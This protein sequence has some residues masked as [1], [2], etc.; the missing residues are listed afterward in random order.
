MTRRSYAN[1]RCIYCTLEKIW[2][3]FNREHV[4]HQ[5]MGK[6][7]DALVLRCVCKPC[8]QHFG[9]T[10]D[11]V[12]GRQSPESFVRVWKGLTT[13]EKHRQHSGSTFIRVEVRNPEL[14]HIQMRAVSTADGFGGEPLKQ[15][16]FSRGEHRKSFLVSEIP[17]A[18]EIANHGFP[19]DQTT[20]I[21]LMGEGPE[22]IVA[23]MV[24]RGYQ[25]ALGEKLPMP[26]QTFRGELVLTVTH[27]HLRA[28]AKIA[29][30]Y[31][32]SELGA[33]TALL[34]QFDRIRR[35]I[36]DD[37]VTDAGLVRALPTSSLTPTSR[38]EQR[39]VHWIALVQSGASLVARV[40]LFSQI[41]YEVLLTEQP[42]EGAYAIDRCHIYDL[43][44]KEVRASSPPVRWAP[45]RGM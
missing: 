10:I 45:V 5:S 12:F 6:F 33:G 44:T 22:E 15:V 31:V 19:L 1:Q 25:I 4:L 37:N 3:D 24:E 36:C 11:L 2:K 13:V 40:C 23:A 34:P 35:Y 17:P 7:K 30:N 21:G 27:P 39:I 41:S 18:S 32:A 43:K 16:I 20:Q 42:F 28:V 29:L 8:N 38:D 26:A 9:D 14:Q